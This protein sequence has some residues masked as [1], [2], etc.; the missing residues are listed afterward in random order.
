MYSIAL[1]VLL[2]L[3]TALVVRGLRRRSWTAM[4]VGLAVATATLVVFGL[5]SFWGEMLWFEEV[6]FLDRFWT[7]VGATVGIAVAAA[8]LSAALVGLITLPARHTARRP[9]RIGMAVAAAAGAAW[10][11]ASWS[12]VLRW[13][14]GGSTG[15]REP[16]FGR[17]TGFY[18]FTLPFYDA[19][20]SLALL[21][22]L[23]SMIVAVWS[24]RGARPVELR[25]LHPGERILPRPRHGA[26]QPVHVAAGTLA[27]ALAGWCT[28]A[29]YHLLYS[30]VGTVHGAGWTDV[31][32]RLPVY[33]VLALLLAIVGI[34]LLLPWSR[35]VLDGQVRRRLPRAHRTPLAVLAVPAALVVSAWLIGLGVLPGLAQWLVVRPN[36][37]ALE[38]PYIASSIAFTRS[39]FGLERIEEREIDIRDAAE[40]SS[41]RLPRELVESKRQLLSEIRLW[42]PR[43]LHQVLQQ[44]QSIRLYYE[45][46]NVDIDRYTVDG[47][48]R[49]MMVAPREMRT[50]NLPEGSRTFVN[51]HFQYTHGYG[52][53]MA[54][55]SDFTKD[56]LPELV[57]RDLPPV[58]DYPS[59]EVKRP[60][61][62]YGELTDD[63]VVV[64]TK[65]LEFDYP[66]GAEN[67]YTHY[68]GNGGVPLHGL[69]RRLAF[70]WKLG[71]TGLLFSEYP[72]DDSRIMFHRNVHER[73]AKIA[74][75]L[76]L[77]HDPY[78]TIVD[79]R[80]KWIV[81]AY[82]T[83]T[84]FPYSETLADATAGRS[85]SEPE[86]WVGE[87]MTSPL[88]GVNYVRNSVKAVVDAYD[89]S[90]SLYVFEPHDPIVRVWRRIFPGLFRPAS[91]MP[92]TLRA[93]VRYPEELLNAQGLVYAKFHMTNPDVFYNQEDLWVR[94]REQRR[95]S[96][97]VVDP[98]YVMWQP[99]ASEAAEL[100]LMQPFT[101][102]NRQVLI[103]WL[104]GMCDGEN[105]GRLL[106]YRFSKD[107]RILGPQ[108]VDTKIDQSPELSAQLT[109]WDQ[110]GKRV[111]RGNILA[112][113]IGETLLYVEPIYLQAEAAAYPEL[114]MVVAMHGDTM[115]YAPTFD[116]ALAGLVAGGAAPVAHATT[117]PGAEESA[118][119][120]ARHAFEEYRR[121]TSEGRFEEAGARLR[122]LGEALAPPPASA[123]PEH[124]DGLP[125]R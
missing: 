68:R 45:L 21:V 12:L 73:I 103:G 116:E 95:G 40:A 55:V 30:S 51:R 92:A 113:P 72:T 80:L 41:D 7:V 125:I 96:L 52:L 82:T 77:D 71:G 94:A 114:R 54:P 49:Q 58:S 64:N 65:A 44:F 105:Y 11:A 22:V 122:A 33:Y 107:K 102:R 26:R 99:P 16:I 25:V 118:L 31:H 86:Q 42:D 91:E 29:P 88:S 63:F 39:G 84:Y 81:D 75:F 101:P 59:L 18:L 4:G 104:A 79:G 48:Y 111:I 106:A 17:D 28:I 119:E 66:S 115:S 32:I 23:I 69:L 20:F 62:Y 109:L 87:E 108:Q 46:S 13:L 120:R 15:Q 83:S 37:L 85:L 36:E 10:G 53:T 90:V 89:G 93:H 61:I 124:G 43:A 24:T 97:G 70:G 6:G 123:P 98:Y 50:A 56:G 117:A 2:A 60:E 19:L 76:L 112:I 3:A 78:I 35:R 1:L 5:F 57:V 74:P 100:I 9:R 121:L 38:R 27:L 34:V 67:A 14:M 8:L 47:R 110:H